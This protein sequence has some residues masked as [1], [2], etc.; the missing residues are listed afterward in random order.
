MQRRLPKRPCCLLLEMRRSDEVSTSGIGTNRT[1]SGGL[2]LPKV[3][4]TCNPL[5]G[6]SRLA[7]S[8][9]EKDC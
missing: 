5:I 2:L 6:R 9:V 3:E 8:I 4:R 7:L 1:C